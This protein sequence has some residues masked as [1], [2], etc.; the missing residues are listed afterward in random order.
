MKYLLLLSLFFSTLSV[1]SQIGINSST[2]GS[3]VLLNVGDK[4]SVSNTGN[5][6]IGTQT[7]NTKVQIVTGGTQVN[8]NPQ[9][10]IED[11][12]QSIGKVLQSDENGV[13]KWV[14]Y[15]PDGVTGTFDP[16]G[17]SI[18]S[19]YTTTFANTK[20]YITLQPGKWIIMYT[21]TFN[22]Q[23]TGTTDPLSRIYVRSSLADIDS[24]SNTISTDI[25]GNTLF[26]NSV[27]L[28]K[29]G[30]ITG[31]CLIENSSTMPKNYYILIG[32]ILRGS[33]V[34]V[35]FTLTNT[36]VGKGNILY[37]FRVR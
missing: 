21:I 28:G 33:N 13:G 24:S 37:A 26:A 6:G 25:I 19:A 20:S 23:Y 35:N 30:N 29:Q 9:L 16:T 27:V 31:R 3:N 32:E 11:G 17:I 14:E 7:S 36:G 10:Q 18:S 8:P 1:S 15:T 34:S 12:N 2:F 22:T 4:V 5:L